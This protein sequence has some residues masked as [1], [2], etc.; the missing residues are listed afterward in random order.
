L[1][2]KTLDWVAISFKNPK[3]V[4]KAQ[5]ENDYIRLE[6][7]KSKMLCINSLGTLA[8]YDVKYQL[9]ISFKD[10]KYKFDAISVD[11]I[12][13]TG[14]STFPINGDVSAY[15]KKNGEIRTSFKLFPEALESTFNGLNKDL[16][17]FLKSETIPSK[18]GD[19]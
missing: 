3:E 10:G 17:N 9:E 16:E 1:Y 13:K 11:I 6:G 19:W 2:K 4:I 8:C 7:F 18:K 12:T 14:T 15:F 5:I